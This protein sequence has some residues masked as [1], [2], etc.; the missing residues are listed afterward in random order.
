[1]YGAR[2]HDLSAEDVA[3]LRRRAGDRPF[4]I[5]VG[6]R[7]RREGDREWLTAIAA[8]GTTWWT[9]YLPAQGRDTMR[10]AVRRGPLRIT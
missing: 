7:E 1:M 10:E 4:D 3:D 5:C 2:T 8:A 6:G 9:E